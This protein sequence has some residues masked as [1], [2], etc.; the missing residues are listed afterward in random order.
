MYLLAYITVREQWSA[1]EREGGGRQRKGVGG[2]ERPHRSRQRRST[3]RAQRISRL[4]RTASS[5]SLSSI[6]IITRFSSSSS[7]SSPSSSTTAAL[8]PGFGRDKTAKSTPAAKATPSAPK[9]ARWVRAS[10]RGRRQDSGAWLRRQKVQ[11]VWVSALPSR[12][13]SNCAWSTRT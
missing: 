11:F 9:W 7:S 6:H 10:I 13:T 1:P 4:W 2:G 5:T 12:V 3:G 8:S